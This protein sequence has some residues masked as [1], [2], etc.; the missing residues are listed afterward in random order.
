MFAT[1]EAD[2]FRQGERLPEFN[3]FEKD[4]TLVAGEVANIPKFGDSFLV[5]RVNHGSIF[6]YS[7][8]CDVV[9]MSL[10]FAL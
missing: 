3:V 10:K 4:K 1:N 8:K 2:P 6:K 7:E 5:D 9:L